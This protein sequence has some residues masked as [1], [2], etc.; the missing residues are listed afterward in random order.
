[1]SSSHAY[2]HE[3]TGVETRKLGMWVF[4]STEILFFG[5]LITTFMIF[6]GKDFPGMKLTDVYDIPFTSIS[7]FILLM[8]SLTMVLAHNA[9]EANDQEK[10]RVWLL[11]TA[12]LGS[13]FLAGQ[14]YEFTEFYHKGFELSTNI[15][16]S[17]F[18][19]KNYWSM[20]MLPE[21]TSSINS[22]VEQYK[23][24]A[25]VFPSNTTTSWDYNESNG[26]VTTT[27]AVTTEVKEGSNTT[28]LLGLLPHQWNNLATNSNTPNEYTYSSVRGVFSK[29]FPSFVFGIIS[30]F[31]GSI[32]TD[33]CYYISLNFRYNNQ[34]RTHPLIQPSCHLEGNEALGISVR[35]NTSIHRHVRFH[36]SI[37][38]IAYRLQRSD[39]DL[40]DSEDHSP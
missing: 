23:Q 11:A 38:H 13:V 24:F 14:I 34:F 29:Y 28:M 19:G 25:Y 6:K 12:M 3:P 15:F 36:N 2:P 4:L 9:L 17:S 26:K 16:S 18:N 20:A 22:L 39:D 7:S 33:I 37:D 27:F 10:T 8:S 35:D 1:M 21:S 30:N 31:S 40:L 32:F 5:T